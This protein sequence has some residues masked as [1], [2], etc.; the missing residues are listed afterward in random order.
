MSEK[1]IRYGLYLPVEFHKELKIAAAL[2]ETTML[3]YMMQA[4]REKLDR[5]KREG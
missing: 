2:A 3:D 1:I 5:D 4:I